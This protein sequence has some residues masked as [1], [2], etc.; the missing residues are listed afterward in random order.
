MTMVAWSPA[1]NVGT[2]IREVFPFAKPI[3]AAMRA[4]RPPPAIPTR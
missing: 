3:A 4:L 2:L 1:R